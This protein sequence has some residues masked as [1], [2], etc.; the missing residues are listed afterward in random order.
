MTSRQ[1]LDK[2]KQFERE[3]SAYSAKCEALFKEVDSDNSGSL[4][5]DE[6]LALTEKMG[7]S[8][9]LADPAS[10][11]TLSVLI[12]DIE[13][14]RKKSSWRDLTLDLDTGLIAR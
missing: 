9:Q 13:K 10:A 5:K 4:D 12:E 8:E 2:L 3:H 7:L 1:F 14:G 11:L 6:V